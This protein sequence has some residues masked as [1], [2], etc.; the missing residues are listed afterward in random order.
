MSEELK[1]LKDLR[2][3]RLKPFGRKDVKISAN[4][5]RAEAIKWVKDL[6]LM[7]REDLNLPEPRQ[8]LMSF[9]N[10]T[11]EDLKNG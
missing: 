5:L 9:F 8:V 3:E 7:I 4:R 11:E 10:I 2:K 6:D 1:T